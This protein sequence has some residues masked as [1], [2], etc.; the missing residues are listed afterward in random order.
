MDVN[1]K[2]CV[3]YVTFRLKKGVSIENFRKCSDDLDAKFLV[4]E[5][6]FI[7]RKLLL[8]HDGETWADLAFWKDTAAAKTAEE[9]FMKDPITKAY[10]ELIDM[11]TI[12]MEHSNEVSHFGK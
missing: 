10:G 7:S 6:G 1:N 4:G 5:G 2:L 12:R 3:E 11:G 9:K 8:L